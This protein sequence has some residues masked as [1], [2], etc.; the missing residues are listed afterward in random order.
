MKKVLQITNVSQ[1]QYNELL[2]ESFLFWA[3]KHT[4]TKTQYQIVLTSKPIKKWFFNQYEKLNAEFVHFIE[5]HPNASVK[6]NERL[7][8][9]MIGKIYEIYPQVLLDDI[10]KQYNGIPIHNLN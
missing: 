2:L 8:A 4:F 7:Y 1:K 9:R 10:K 3:G 5:R 6:D